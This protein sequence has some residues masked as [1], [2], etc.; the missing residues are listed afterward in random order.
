MWSELVYVLT[1]Q[2]MQKPGE[3]NKNKVSEVELLCEVLL[4]LLQPI[5]AVLDLQV[6]LGPLE[7]VANDYPYPKTWGLKKIKFLAYPEAKL[8]H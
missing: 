3:K 4:D 2:T 1:I 6:N 7:M 8:L 5:Q